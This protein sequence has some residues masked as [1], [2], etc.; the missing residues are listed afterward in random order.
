MLKN[1]LKIALRNLLRHRLFT[2]INVVGLALGAACCALIGLYIQHEL[3]YDRF[4]R[5]PENVF[6]VMVESTGEEGKSLSSTT[7]RF[8]STTLVENFPEIESATQFRLM[9]NTVEYQDKEYLET[10][11]IFSD[12]AFFEVFT[13]P[14]LEGDLPKAL[15]EPNAAVLTK[16]FARK[17]FGEENPVGKSFVV[18][19]N[20]RA[21]PQA[22][23][24]VAALMEDVPKNAHFKFNAVL[25]FSLLT[26]PQTRTGAISWNWFG[27][28]TYIRLKPQIDRQGVEQK[29]PDLVQNTGGD[30]SKHK[31]VLQPLTDIHLS[32]A[33]PFDD[34]GQTNARD[35]YVFAGIALLVLVIACINYMVLVTARYTQRLKE[36]GVRKIIGATAP[37]LILQFLFET[38]LIA[39]L[40]LPL[41]LGIV[42]M[43]HRSFGG[44]LGK[45]LQIDY[46]NNQIFLWGNLFVLIFFIV[47]AGFYPALFFSKINAVAMLKGQGAGVRASTRLRKSL[48][49]TQFGVTIALLVCVGTMYEQLQYTRA[50]DLGYRHDDLLV[51]KTGGLEKQM[52]VLKQA[53]L[54]HSAVSAATLSSWLPGYL[55][56]ETI[57]PHPHGEG[58]ITVEFVEAD[59][60]L[61]K[62]FQIQLLE[63]RDFNCSSPNDTLSIY[64]NGKPDFSLLPRVSILL[65]ETAVQALG[66]ESPIGKDVNYSALQGTIIGVIKD[67]HNRSLHHPIKP[68]VIKYSDYAEQLV[69]AY[70]PGQEA[71]VLAHLKM[72]WEKLTTKSEFT[73]L[74]LNDH[75]RQLYTTEE[76]LMQMTTWFAGLAI[77]LS[78]LGLFGMAV[79]SIERRTK[80]IGIRKVLGAS[81]GGVVTLL[82]K[83]FVKLVLLA[84]LIAW[85]VAWYAMSKWLQDFAYRIELG[86]WTFAL[87]GGV[88][89]FIALLTVSAQAIRAALANPVEALRYE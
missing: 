9:D 30:R 45:E 84:N 88:A 42:E 11:L 69:V 64:R 22:E 35:L 74:F 3:S 71:E 26:S 13:F 73:H 38:A 81:V 57:M 68:M 24:K 47:V 63:G 17:I 51:V 27:E 39:V 7:P 2:S 28:K 67:M 79:F 32:P 61:L 29:L 1:Y 53:A 19:L 8:L 66:L 83:D 46:F 36:V 48:V 56:A 78:C 14:S 16:S 60:D 21:T 34:V 4:H 12:P 41:A 5:E 37:K 77:A 86:W 75:L 23:V 72:A 82:S 50:K 80:E 40:T 15:A 54:S 87:A 10:R 89:L 33:I 6:R 43:A 85:P 70:Q 25:P 55:T 31:L 49:I 18:R 52:D 62:T 59:C 44:L 65:N 20:S 76:K 58:T